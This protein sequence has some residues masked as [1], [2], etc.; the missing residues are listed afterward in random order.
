MCWQRHRYCDFFP[1]STPKKAKGRIKAQSKRGTFGER[2]WA[3]PWIAVLEG[4]L[5]A[6]IFA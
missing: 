4:R 3:K 6:D 1:R 5:G 2:W